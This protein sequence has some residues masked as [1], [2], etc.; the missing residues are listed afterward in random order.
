MLYMLYIMSCAFGCKLRTHTVNSPSFVSP[1]SP[2]FYLLIPQVPPLALS[3][4]IWLSYYPNIIMLMRSMAVTKVLECAVCGHLSAYLGVYSQGDAVLLLTGGA[5]SPVTLLD[6]VTQEHALRPWPWRPW[7]EEKLWYEIAADHNSLFLYTL[8]IGQWGKVMS[9]SMQTVSRGMIFILFIKNNFLCNGCPNVS[10]H[11]HDST[12]FFSYIILFPAIVLC[13]TEETWS[14][15]GNLTS[16]MSGASG[17]FELQHPLISAFMSESPLLKV[18]VYVHSVM[19][20]VLSAP[21]LSA[22]FLQLASV[23]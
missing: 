11:T 6:R 15:Y 9:L 10:C 22:K 4:S 3:V 2:P 20:Y 8:R 19:A 13:A 7:W 17:I 14:T 5:R 12:L 21:A 18:L 1:K 23:K 16:F